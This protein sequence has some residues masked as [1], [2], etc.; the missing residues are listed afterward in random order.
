MYSKSHFARKEVVTNIQG[1]V[2]RIEVLKVFV[3]KKLVTWSRA[4][5][6]TGGFK[7]YTKCTGH[8][9]ST[10]PSSQFLYDMR[11][12]CLHNFDILRNLLKVCIDS[13]EITPS[14]S[15]GVRPR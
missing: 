2:S 9:S 3:Y 7:S 4:A 10:S 13:Q 12:I 5:V 14:G 15:N 1:I 6:C 11:N 8:T